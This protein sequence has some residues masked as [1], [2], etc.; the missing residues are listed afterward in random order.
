MVGLGMNLAVDAV[1]NANIENT[2]IFAAELGI[3]EGDMRVLGLVVHWL[4]VHQ[5]HIHVDR[6]VRIVRQQRNLRMLAFWAAVGA[7]LGR[8]RRFSRLAELYD[9]ERMPLLTAGNDFQVKRRGEDPRFACTCL[10][11]PAGTLRKRDADILDPAAVVG[12]HHGYRNRVM[13]GP[14]WRADVWTALETNPSLSA[15]AAARE[16]CCAF[17]TAW[18]VK[19]DFELVGNGWPIKGA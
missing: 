11:A 5:A 19:R 14:S 12:V 8:D 17:A 4:D 1:A 15:A 18:Q 16:A 3:V 10:C 2:L 6:L 7:W 13:M 9:G